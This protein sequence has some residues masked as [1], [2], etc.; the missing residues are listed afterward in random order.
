MT[1]PTDAEI[2]AVMRDG[3]N[4]RYND[5]QDHIDF[6]RAVLAKW[7]APPAVAGEHKP[8]CPALGGYG[9]G[10]EECCCGAT[11]QPTQAQ[12]T[13]TPDEN[14][15]EKLSRIE[16]SSTATP[17]AVATVTVERYEIPGGMR[18]ALADVI[19][20]LRSHSR[21]D[22]ARLMQELYD[23][24]SPWDCGECS[25]VP[26][27]LVPVRPD[28]D[29]LLAMAR[30]HRW[31]ML[32]RAHIKSAARAANQ[33]TEAPAPAKALPYE[34]T[35][36]MLI[37]AREC[38]PALPIDTIRAIWWA[39][40]RTAPAAP[41]VLPEPVASVHSDTLAMLQSGQCRP[42]DGGAKLHPPGKA[43]FDTAYTYLYATPQ[44]TQAQALD[45]LVALSEQAGLYE[46]DFP[47]KRGQV[48]EPL[49]KFISLK[50]HARRD[51][52]AVVSLLFP[53]HEAADAWVR[54]I[55]K[56]QA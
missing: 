16:A 47:A 45:E 8:G 17:T 36:A 51:K 34:P 24:I 42:W 11:P 14:Q 49:P 28:A 23:A 12:A 26:D 44:P 40:W 18:A 20:Y 33:A 2:V 53:G 4:C 6:A 35:S 3:Y 55:T 50:F 39:M 31:P 7:A 56:E 37:A 48:R 21:H 10:V 5:E 46:H 15:L 41:V 27:A 13:A 25:D 22:L 19:T 29:Y 9:H 52:T 30:N 54:G 1:E 43:R 32:M 38:D